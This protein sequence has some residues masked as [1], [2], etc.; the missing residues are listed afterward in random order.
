MGYVET[1]RGQLFEANREA[2][3]LAAAVDDQLG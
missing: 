1:V 3:R 2:R